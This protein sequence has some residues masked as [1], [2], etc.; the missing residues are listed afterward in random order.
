[1]LTAAQIASRYGIPVSSINPGDVAN[2]NEL[3]RKGGN[4]EYYIQNS[5]NDGKGATGRQQNPG[6][7][8]DSL[9]NAQRTAIEGAARNAGITLTDAQK[10]QIGADPNNCLLYTSPSPRD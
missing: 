9:S 1:M 5:L 8:W 7:T 6:G 4:V 2:I 10:A 3:I